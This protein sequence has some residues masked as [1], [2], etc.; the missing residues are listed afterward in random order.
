[1]KDGAKTRTLKP[2]NIAFEIVYDPDQ[3][4]LGGITIFGFAARFVDTGPA[5]RLI[6]LMNW[7]PQATTPSSLF[8]LISTSLG[9]GGFFYLPSGA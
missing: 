5:S 4:M 8:S 6:M 2:T 7:P 9:A 3:A 1:M